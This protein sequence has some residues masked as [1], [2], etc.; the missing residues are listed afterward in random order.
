MDFICKKDFII[1]PYNLYDVK[2]T[3]LLYLMGAFFIF[4]TFFII[5]RNFEKSFEVIIFL[6]FLF[7]GDL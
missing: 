4:F 5:R 3:I 1:G 7:L 6:E 2:R